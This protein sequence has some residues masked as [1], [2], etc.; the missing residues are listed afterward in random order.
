VDTCEAFE[1]IVETERELLPLIRQLPVEDWPLIRQ[2][3]WFELINPSTPAEPRPVQPRLTERIAAAVREAAQASHILNS[4][5]IESAL[6]FFSRVTYL[7]SLPDGSQFDRVID[8]LVLAAS[9]PPNCTK[10]YLTPTGVNDLG[11]LHLPAQ[12]TGIDLL[13]RV[14]SRLTVPFRHRV[15]TTFNTCLHELSVRLGVTDRKLR[16]GFNAQRLAYEDWYRF[17][18][19]LFAHYRKVRR[20]FV[21]A[22]YFP[23]S[24][25]LIA[26]ARRYGIESIDVQHG[27]QGPY[28]AMYAGW[29]WIPQNGFPNLPDK[30]WC[31]GSP[32]C[33]HILRSSPDRSTH[34]PF[35][36]GYPWLGWYRDNLWPDKNLAQPCSA[37]H[38]V[39][40]TLQPPQGANDQPMPSALV[41]ALYESTHVSHVVIRNHPNWAGG[42]SYA[43]GRFRANSRVRVEVREPR[44]PVLDDLLW[45]THHI[46]AYSSCCYEAEALGRPTLLVGDDAKKIYAQSIAE[47]RFEWAQSTD[48]TTIR[49]WL[50]RASRAS[51]CN[52]KESIRSSYLLPDV[53]EYGGELLTLSDAGER[54]ISKTTAAAE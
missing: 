22:W 3:L 43:N 8:P 51:V 15:D 4:L 21:A 6:L 30:Y 2:C 26:A 25:G 11:K 17:G 31:W 1:R 5:N 24:M 40:I 36:G 47:G 41:Q 20:I 38:R 23:D 28:Q 9:H 18:L 12:P 52:G 46:T 49:E 32:S 37:T 16:N 50:D 35:A 7:T 19:K 14:A 39:L 29:T 54:S 10:Y 33:E 13:P 42:L 48:K 44:C 45:C 53:S 34:R 27:K